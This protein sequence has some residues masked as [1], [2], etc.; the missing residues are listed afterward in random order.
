M[1]EKGPECVGGLFARP[2]LEVTTCAALFV[3]ASQ[4]RRG[5]G[6][7]FREKTKSA[8]MGEKSANNIREVNN[9]AM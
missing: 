9:R 6:R 4:E 3:A 2:L 1:E 7:V 5:A 8:R